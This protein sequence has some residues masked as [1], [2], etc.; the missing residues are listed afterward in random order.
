MSI[1]GEQT[2]PPCLRTGKAKTPQSGKG[3]H[4]SCEMLISTTLC[5]VL[6]GRAITEN[7]D[8]ELLDIRWV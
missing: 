7:I 1:S 5:A 3:S 4:V 8:N 6:P 2:R